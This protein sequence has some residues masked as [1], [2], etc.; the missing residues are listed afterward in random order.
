MITS[1]QMSQLDLRAALFAGLSSAG[2][3]VAAPAVLPTGA[4]QVSG[5]NFGAWEEASLID[6]YTE[7]YERL[8]IMLGPIGTGS[9][10]RIQ[11]FV[12]KAENP[13]ARSTYGA[14]ASSKGLSELVAEI[15]SSLA[16]QIKE[17]AEV[18]GVERPT[19]YAWIKGVSAPQKHNQSRL[20]QLYRIS[21]AWNRLSTQ[22]VG[23][24][25]REVDESGA[26]VLDHLRKS[27]IPEETILER[28]RSIASRSSAISPKRRSSL[29][30]FARERGINLQ[31][32]IE[33][34][35][36]VDVTT[37]KRASLE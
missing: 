27:P 5:N 32:V 19:V 13:A 29:R 9:S 4:I 6:A 26:S 7:S 10:I 2:F 36:V 31:G 15:R 30:E 22:P 24:M 11:D 37:G 12:V 33:Q 25:L 18:V 21:Q 17:F 3:A 28:F 35:D 23:G 1:E 16:L 8:P 20:R 14:L 34:S